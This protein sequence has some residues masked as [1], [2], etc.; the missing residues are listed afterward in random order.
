MHLEPK[1]KALILADIDGE[2]CPTLCDTGCQKSC[3]SENLLRRHPTFFKNKI[4]PH[5]GKTISIDG[6]K[7]ETIGTINIQFRI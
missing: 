4:Q 6:S 2:V 3:I 5:K 1:F 7:V